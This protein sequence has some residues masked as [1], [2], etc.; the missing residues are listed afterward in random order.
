LN[1]A[2]YASDQVGDGLI[3][4]DFGSTRAL[5]FVMRNVNRERVDHAAGAAFGSRP[6]VAGL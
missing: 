4:Q 1:G 5:R 6:A 3:C 2:V